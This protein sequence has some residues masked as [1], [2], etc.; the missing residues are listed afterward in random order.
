MAD[1]FFGVFPFFVFS[2]PYNGGV[3]SE[4]IEPPGSLILEIMEQ[5]AQNPN[6]SS[7][8]SHV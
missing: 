6:S 8:D 3:E 2:F 4:E 5:N 7:S 1:T